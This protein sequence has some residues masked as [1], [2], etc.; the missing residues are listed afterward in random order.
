M[1]DQMAIRSSILR[2][3][4][5]A[6]RLIVESPANPIAPKSSINPNEG[7]GSTTSPPAPGT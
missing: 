5:H 4:I 7:S 6:P 3:L 2:L 1:H